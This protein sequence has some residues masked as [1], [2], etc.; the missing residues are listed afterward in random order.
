MKYLFATL[1]VSF[2][3]VT[4]ESFMNHNSPLTSMRRSTLTTSTSSLNSMMPMPF[5]EGPTVG[6]QDMPGFPED[7]P[8]GVGP[9][10][11]SP[12]VP[13]GPNGPQSMHPD[14]RGFGGQQHQGDFYGGGRGGYDNDYWYENPANNWNS[15]TNGWNNQGASSSKWWQSGANQSNS[16]QGNSRK[17]WSSQDPWNQRSSHVHLQSERPYSPLTATVD[18]LQGPGNTARKMRVY[19]EDG[20]ARPLRANF[21]NPSGGSRGYSNTID[22]KNTGPLEF[23]MAAGVSQSQ[24]PMMYGGG[25]GGGRQ[26]GQMGQMNDGPM[27]NGQQQQQGPMMNGQ[28]QQQMMGGGMTGG[29]YKE[30]KTVQGGSLKTYSFSPYVNYVQVDIETDGMPCYAKIEVSQGPGDAR[31]TYEVY[32]DDGT[33]W[34]GIVETPGYGCTILIKNKGPM[35]YPIKASCEPME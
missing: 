13:Y 15:N 1:C 12:M 35:A 8:E 27:M 3:A 7:L 34:Q 21:A 24:Q 32:S 25:G 6:F 19:S 20:Y 28:Q 29:G 10:P 31:Q 11:G 30:M 22:V 16:L 9:L 17:T 26:M 14:S 2:H 5:S 4:V 23:P 18:F 33:P